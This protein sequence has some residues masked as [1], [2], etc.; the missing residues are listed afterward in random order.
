MS[1]DISPWRYMELWLHPLRRILIKYSKEQELFLVYHLHF[2]TIREHNLALIFGVYFGP[3]APTVSLE[4]LAIMYEAYLRHRLIEM[5]LG[6][7]SAAWVD[8]AYFEAYWRSIGFPG[9][10]YEFVLNPVTRNQGRS[11]VSPD[12]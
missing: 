4:D 1:M 2:T 5:C 11:P 7:L 10:P 8:I 6:N 3:G 12:Q 9:V